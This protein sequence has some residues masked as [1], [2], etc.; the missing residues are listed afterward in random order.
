[1]ALPSGTFS[2]PFAGLLVVTFSGVYF[3]GIRSDAGF[4]S[5][6]SNMLLRCT[7]GPY[8][9]GTIDRGAQSI[10]NTFVYPGGVNWAIAATEISSVGSG[11]AAYGF[12][13]ISITC[14]L[15]KR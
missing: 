15:Y 10:V 9:T 11:T 5:G 2:S 4:P 7:V 8:K 12:K 6:S 1:M 3:Q 13:D 14:L